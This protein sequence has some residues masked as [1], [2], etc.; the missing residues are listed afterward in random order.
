VCVCACACVCVC[1]YHEIDAFAVD[2]AGDTNDGDRVA[3]ARRGVG[4][5]DGS[6]DGVGNDRDVF[7]CHLSTQH[8]ILF[9]GVRHTDDVVRDP[10]RKVEHLP[11]PLLSSVTAVALV[12]P[13]TCTP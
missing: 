4:R 13:H 11:P 9:A 1:R 3:L 10:A 2:K 5:E 7:R 6:V 12:H 8:C